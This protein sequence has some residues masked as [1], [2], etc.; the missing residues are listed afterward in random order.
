M[1]MPAKV[2]VIS[3]QDPVAT[4]GVMNLLYL[5][6]QENLHHSPSAVFSALSPRF[7][8]EG[9]QVTFSDS[10]ASLTPENL[11][12][13]D[14]LMMY[15]NAQSSGLGSPDQPLV[16]IIVEYVESGGSLVGL[17]VASAAFRNDTRFSSLLGGRFDSHFHANFS[18][19]HI[20]PEH[21]LI[22]DLTPL[23]SFDE[24]YILKDIN[25]DI[26]VLQE[27]V[28]SAT[29][30]FPWTWIRTQK[31]G[32]VF[33]TASGHVPATGETDRY[34]SITKPEFSDLVLRGLQ[35][36]TKRHFSNFSNISPGNGHT[37]WGEGIHRNTGKACLW[38]DGGFGPA[39]TIVE[40]DS[41][42]IGQR[43]FIWG[44]ALP[45]TFVPC[46]DPSNSVVFFRTIFDE[47]DQALS[48][49]WVST[50]TT[51]AEPWAIVGE[52]LPDSD[53][54]EIVQTLGH[55]IGTDFVTNT[56]ADI[57]F[58]ATLKNTVSSE[59][60]AT[61]VK[62]SAGIILGPN[63]IIPGLPAATS[64]ADLS[65]GALTMNDQG[66]FA[67]ELILSNGATALA[68]EA[69]S[70]ISIGLIEG[71]NAPGL[72][73]VEWGIPS[74]LNL[75][76]SDD[77]YFTTTLTGNVTGETDSALVKYSLGSQQFSIVLREGDEL[78]TSTFVGDLSSTKFVI[79]DQNEC[80]LFTTLTGSATSLMNDQA[81]ISVTDS[82]KIIVREG[83]SLP[84]LGE[85]SVIGEKL[86]NTPLATDKNGNLYFTANVIDGI[87]SRAQLF[88]VI[89]STVFGV[90]ASGE[91]IPDGPG[92]IYT[93][94]TI[95]PFP[96]SNI[97]GGTP[98][99]AS[100]Q[101][102]A[103]SIGTTGN[104]R[105]ALNLQNLNDLD[106]DGASNI[107]E[108]GLASD[109]LDPNS[110]VTFPIIE[111]SDGALHYT[112][113]RA[114]VTGLPTPIVQ[115]SRDLRTWNSSSAT[116]QVWADQTS[117]P[118]GY[119]KVGIPLK[120]IAWEHRFLRLLF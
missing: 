21:A 2:E 74:N 34:N 99:P 54:N 19:E 63:D 23:T 29:Q 5:G 57:L 52:P 25:P 108:A 15:G 110:K 62:G 92:T 104:H 35:W 78:E 40:G 96:Q 43:T 81:I 53:N 9:V 55:S 120:R 64:I 4:P 118:A 27:R 61:L 11:A 60:R 13:Y 50:P 111:P 79:D 41:F 117:V 93:V 67:C 26:H 32:R 100:H 83:N 102:L 94:S 91:I 45:H 46:Q 20:D 38:L 87:V 98:S 103:I 70:T 116:P 86:G 37:Y 109:P 114:I 22:K 3:I 48:A 18:P 113:L 39:I 115:E 8:A 76:N 112:F 72:S 42:A 77:L 14:A 51:M 7:Q 89:D 73:G 12:N 36:T 85:G 30:R 97:S 31:S 75:L 69:N 119:E 84:T 44:E 47:T 101:N 17:H 68:I 6:Y 90:L 107:L 28:Y 80:H 33:Y 56:N 10:L 65:G 82:A 24:T 88:Q 66:N 106:G 59:S 71:E 58:R 49:L 16:P 95:N 1:A 105:L